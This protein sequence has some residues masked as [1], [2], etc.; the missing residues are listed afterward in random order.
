MRVLTGALLATVLA[1]VTVSCSKL[2]TGSSDL[3]T[4]QQKFGYAVGADLGRSIKPVQ[5]DIDLKALERGM[6]D[7]A[8]GKP[9]AM[10]DQARQQ[11]K[12]AMASKIRQEQN[13]AR[14]AAAKTNQD[15]GD[16]FLA[17]NGKRAGVVTTASGLQYESLKEGTGPS[18]T[19][20][21]H[22]TVN[23]VGTLPDGTVFDKSPQPVTF[24][25]GNV[26]PGWVE[27]VQKMKE[28]GKAK[29]YIPA[30]L[31]YGNMG[32]GAKIGPNQTLIF[33]VELLKVTSASA[34]AS[35][36]AASAKTK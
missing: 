27:G 16:K 28:G 17:E 29:L 19:P 9:L 13:D 23:Y 8:A 5:N 10:D 3:K 4:D 7:A 20:A 35:S 26:I 2:Q 25:L 18:P 11:I 1:C 30:R 33:D 22:V 12:M 6:E 32:A 31:G 36:S 15:A 14:T 24:E 34:A 21:D